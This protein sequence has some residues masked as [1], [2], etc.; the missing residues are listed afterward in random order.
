MP[1]L[2]CR[3][4]D[5]NGFGCLGSQ[6]VD[7]LTYTTMGPGG[8]PVGNAQ[9]FGKLARF[10]FQVELPGGIRVDEGPIR[11]AIEQ[12]QITA[13]TLRSIAYRLDPNDA[14][15]A[16]A[17]GELDIVAV[18]ASPLPSGTYRFKHTLA[19]VWRL[20]ETTLS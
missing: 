17:E 2:K 5:L 15:I 4:G 8:Q 18:A 6:L 19:Q 7:S 20:T 9:W 14:R 1:D 11:T 3:D 13:A 12:Q 16:Y 10:R